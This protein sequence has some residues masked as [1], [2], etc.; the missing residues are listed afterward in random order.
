MIRLG[1]PVDAAVLPGSIFNYVKRTREQVVLDD[2]VLDAR[3]SADPYII[4]QRARSVLCLPVVR[5][6]EIV[7]LFYLEN[8]LMT[9]AFTPDRLAVLELLTSQAAIS[10]ENAALYT[11]MSQENADRKRAE[12]EVRKLN[13]ELERRVSDRTAQ[14]SAANRELEAFSS[15]VS[16]DLRALS[17]RSTASARPSWRTTV[18]SWTTRARVT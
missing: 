18:T 3:F 14:L 9:G 8:S 2:A 11:N 15:S 6:T 13:E 4:E 10:L 7:G 17:G 5:Q 12:A 16:H 1:S